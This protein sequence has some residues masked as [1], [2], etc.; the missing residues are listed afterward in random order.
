MNIKNKIMGAL[1]SLENVDNEHDK[2]SEKQNACILK[3]VG[4]NIYYV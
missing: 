2:T 3:H 1:L 4:E